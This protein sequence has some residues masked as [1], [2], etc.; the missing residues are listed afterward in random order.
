MIRFWSRYGIPARL[1]PT[2][3]FAGKYDRLYLKGIL[4]NSQIHQIH[5]LNSLNF[6]LIY[7]E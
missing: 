2:I 7:F 6:R 1:E 4:K 3:G 5:P